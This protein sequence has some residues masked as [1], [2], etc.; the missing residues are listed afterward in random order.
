MERI[1]HIPTN[2]LTAYESLLRGRAYAKV[3]KKSTNARA[4]TMFEKA[5]ALDPAMPGAMEFW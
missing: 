5:I 1:R 4:R 3:R 2:N